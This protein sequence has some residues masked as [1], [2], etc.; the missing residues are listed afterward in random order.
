MAV[1]LAFEGGDEA[2]LTIGRFGEATGYSQRGEF[3]E[4]EQPAESLEAFAQF[5][6]QKQDS[7]KMANEIMRHAKTLGVKPENVV[8]DRTG[9]GTGV[10]DILCARFGDVVGVHF[11]TGA[12]DM[13]VLKEDSAPASALYD[14]M[15][16]ELWFATAKWLE[17]GYLRF[18]EMMNM[19]QLRVELSGRR[20]RQKKDLLRVEGKK[21]FMARGHKSPDKADSLTLLVHCARLIVTDEPRVIR[22]IA[23]NRVEKPKTAEMDK[24]AYINFS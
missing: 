3:I 1:D 14:G 23:N 5:A 21:D 17:F 24:L 12:T 10:H 4:M 7:L 16:S 6:L 19:Q 2:V 22:K 15:V 11:G 9:N 13:P 20:F 8:V 18:S